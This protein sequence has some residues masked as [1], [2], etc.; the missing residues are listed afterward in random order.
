DLP[1][2]WAVLAFPPFGVATA[3]AYQWLDELRARTPIAPEPRRLPRTWLGGV[4]P[5]VNDL[6]RPVVAPHPASGALVTQ[7]TKLGAAMAAMS[8]S[9]STLVG[10]FMAARSAGCAARPRRC[11]GTVA[12]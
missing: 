4:S 2:W 3:D 6:A 1:R 7:L 9:G 5:P 11:S 10:I 8:G 12:V